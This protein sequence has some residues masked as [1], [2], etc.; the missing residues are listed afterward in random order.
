VQF[1][2]AIGGGHATIITDDPSPQPVMLRF[3]TSP[4]PGRERSGYPEYLKVSF[5]EVKKHFVLIP[6]LSL[7]LAAQS[8]P[9]KTTTPAP[10]AQKPATKPAP[11][12]TKPAPAT[13]TTTPAKPATEPGPDDIIA[14]INGVCAVA[15]PAE[16][17]KRTITRAEFERV[18]S[19]VSP[20][21]TPENRRPLAAQYIQLLTMA[22]EAE[23]QGLDKEPSFAERLR[24]ERLRVLAQ[25]VERKLQETSKPT[26]QDVENFYAENSNRF[27]EFSLRRIV[28]PK[29]INNEAKVEEMKALAEKLKARAAA[30]EDPDKLEAE[31]YATAKMPG[32][33]PMTS[34][35][36][37]RRGAMDPRHEPQI[38][39]LKAGQLSDVI[40]DAQSYYIYKVDA[41]R[42]IPLSAVKED[43]ERGL[44]GQAAENRIRALLGTIRVEMNDA[45]FGPSPSAVTPQQPPPA[46]P[47]KQ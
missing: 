19:V 2:Q 12:Q 5:H 4:R 3:R 13:T 11:A 23:K 41:K 29:T 28:V 16:S 24:L 40:E 14:T 39:Q 10:T 17:C 32:A 36:W 45:Y 30:G 6:L 47:P 35:G 33:P 1:G 22:N 7:G 38:I 37:K 15:T 34:L 20:A 9:A 43:L 44:S 46:A 8:A 31:A 25:L 26:E 27:E 18:V 21:L 42:I